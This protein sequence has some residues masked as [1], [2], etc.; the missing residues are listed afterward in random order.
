MKAVIQ[1]VSSARVRV[2]ERTVGE[3][4]KGFLV[5]LGVAGDDTGRDADILAA[6]TARLRVFEDGDGKMNLSL[7]DVGGGVLCVSQF[8]LLADVRKGNR[9]S[10]T[11]AAAPETA[12]PLYERY[13]DALKKEG[14]SP[15]AHGEFGA[16]MQVSLVNDGP[17]TI[18]YDSE[19]WR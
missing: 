18:L 2:G 8:T 5:L 16:D 13:M 14:V 12:I 9:P 7:G 10:F 1:R 3:I 4:G 11:P 19:I 17:V 6:K 15:V